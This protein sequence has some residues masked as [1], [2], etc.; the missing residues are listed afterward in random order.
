[1]CGSVE[2]VE[3]QNAKSRFNLLQCTI[4]V[5]DTIFLCF[6]PEILKVFKQPAPLDPL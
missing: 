3:L 1:M 5:F 6:L 2:N 4:I